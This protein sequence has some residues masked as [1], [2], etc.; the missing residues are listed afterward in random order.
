[1]KRHNAQQKISDDA[2]FHVLQ[3]YNLENKKVV[4]N[5]KLM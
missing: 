3:I 2:S 4:L 5:I 1:L